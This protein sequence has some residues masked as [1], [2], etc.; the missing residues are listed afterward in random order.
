MIQIRIIFEF[1]RHNLFCEK[2]S[3]W[4]L[5]WGHKKVHRAKYYHTNARFFKA[6][7]NKTIFEKVHNV[8]NNVY[9]PYIINY[10]A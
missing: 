9:K 8:K 5:S 1:K 6:I 4:L 7:K 10:V 2:N 3:F